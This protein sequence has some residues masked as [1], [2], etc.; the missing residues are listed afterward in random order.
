M[1]YVRM[2]PSFST[3]QQLW[4][5]MSTSLECGKGRPCGGLWHPG[6][7]RLDGPCLW[8]V[9][10]LIMA[11]AGGEPRGTQIGPELGR[12]ISVCPGVYRII[13]VPLVA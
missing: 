1:L 5:V 9:R 2:G 12:K 13:H 4:G 11:V 7:L 3:R 6:D 10:Q 8:P